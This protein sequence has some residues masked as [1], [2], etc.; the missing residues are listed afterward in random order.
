MPR[1]FTTP[2]LS[3]PVTLT[4]AATIAVN[5]AL[6]NHFRVTLAG[7]R[8]LG[9]P[10]NPVDGQKILLEVIQDATGSRTLT[11][12][13]AF[14]FGTDLVSPTLTTTASKRDFLGFVYT[15]AAAKWYLIGVVRG[16]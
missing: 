3:V 13:T 8:A 11:Y 6:S 5:A 7:N 9:N 12:G 14:A 16:Y 15:A 10:T 4:D 2:I 1:A